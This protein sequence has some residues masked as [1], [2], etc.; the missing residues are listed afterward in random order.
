MVKPPLPE[1]RG[2]KAVAGLLIAYVV[3][4]LLVDT[5]ATQH[6][7]WP[8]AWDVFIWK[9][10]TIAPALAAM[11]PDAAWTHHFIAFIQSPRASNFD[12]FKVTFWFVVPVLFTLPWMDWAAVG[13]RRWKGRDWALLAFAAVAGMGAMFLIPHL[14]GVSDY[15]Q[16]PKGITSSQKL[17]LFL[18]Y[19]AWTASWLPG[20]EFL[21]RY[22]L[23]AALAV[24]FPR[25]TKGWFMVPL[26]VATSEMAYHLVK[27]WPETLAMF[28]FGFL[29]T[30][31]AYQRSN[32]LLPFIA[33]WMI[34]LSLVLFLVLSA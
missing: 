10:R 31:W 30:A 33:H 17:S 18:G 9:P 3:A 5:L 16:A 11:L 24:F 34:E 15:Y 1:Y 6:V 12:L 13:T 19:N 20:W 32:M 2:G 21:H 4:V 14:P 22:V 8:F 29:A 26:V 7:K 27:P 23:L 25:G 28:G